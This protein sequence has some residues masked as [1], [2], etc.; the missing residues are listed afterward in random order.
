MEPNEH[1]N[2]AINVVEY[3]QH[4]LEEKVTFKEIALSL[5]MKDP[6]KLKRLMSKKLGVNFQIYHQYD[7]QNL[8]TLLQEHLPM[9]ENLVQWGIRHV[10][11][12]LTLQSLYLR[13]P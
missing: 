7:E 2:H 3:M 5:G 13:V 9:E 6:H 4:M 11:A 12:S 1:I 10:K 8:A